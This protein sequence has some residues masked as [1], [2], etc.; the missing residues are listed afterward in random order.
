MKR[1]SRS[2]QLAGLILCG[3]VLAACGSAASPSASGGAASATINVAASASSRADSPA[4]PTPEAAAASWVSPK[5]NA[6]VKTYKVRL[7]ATS[8]GTVARIEFFVTSPGKST[9]ACVARKP[10]VA[11]NWTCT[12]DLLKLGVVP[13]E[14]SFSFDAT[15]VSSAVTKAPAGTRTVT[16]AVPPPAPSGATY[17]LVKETVTGPYSRLF[18]YRATWVEPTGYATK[19]RVYG[20]IPCL[21]SSK[22]N[23]GRPCVVSGTTIPTGA[24]K[25]IATLDGTKRSAVIS[26]TE[27]GEL[28]GPGPYSAYLV[29][30]SNQYGSS[31]YT[32]LWSADV[33]WECVY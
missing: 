18:E 5:A 10:D 17:K 33:C 8:V 21:R 7:S 26:W 22:A 20:L 1:P 30:A 15:D 32:I 24:V 28:P 12:A 23:N 25:V 6:T 3:V 13:G 19:F 16:Y 2:A 14:V 27:E 9:A 11:G 31:T 29:R 4:S